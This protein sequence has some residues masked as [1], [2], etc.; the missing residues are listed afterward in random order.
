MTVSDR[1]KRRGHSFDEIELL[2]LLARQTSA[3][4]LNLRLSAQ[5]QHTKRVEALQSMSA[6][7]LHD[8]KNL[9]QRFSMTAKNLVVHF[10]NPECTGQTARSR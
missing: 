6:F 8:L 5:I 4:L 2:R 7:L 3:G 1:V 9:A 10:D